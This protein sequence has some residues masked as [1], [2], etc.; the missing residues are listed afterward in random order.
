MPLKSNVQQLYKAHFKHPLG[1]KIAQNTVEDLLTAVD[2]EPPNKT[3]K[4]E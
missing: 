2:Q 4:E 3:V 1:R